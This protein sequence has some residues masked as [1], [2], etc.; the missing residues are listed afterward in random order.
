MAKCRPRHRDPLGK[1]AGN[2]ERHPRNPGD[3]LI[4]CS[5]RSDTDGE[6]RCVTVE[7]DSESC[8]GCA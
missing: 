5:A 4:I 7:S 6:A 2:T 1:P 8:K 3:K